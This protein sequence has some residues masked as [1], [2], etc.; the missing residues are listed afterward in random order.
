MSMGEKIRQM[1]KRASLTQAELAARLELSPSTIG[2]Y[3]QDR[4]EPDSH[5][6]NRLCEI[7]GVS[8]DYFIG[9]SGHWQT[10]GTMEVSDVFDEFT[11]RLTV[12]EGLMFDGVPLNSEDRRKIID[13]IQVV[14][15]IAKQQHK[16]ASDNKK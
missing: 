9:N 12:Q 14:A 10:N 8:G 15:A 13:A 2:M 16:N 3:E 6:L 7:F 4:R 5:T 1:R 11:R